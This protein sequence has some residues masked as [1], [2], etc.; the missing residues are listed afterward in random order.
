MRIS[1]SRLF[2]LCGLA[3]QMML[4]QVPARAQD[5]KTE[6]GPA[7]TTPA[8]NKRR[9]TPATSVP[10]R[11]GSEV[12]NPVPATAT[13]PAPPGT[14]AKRVDLPAAGRGAVGAAPGASVSGTMPS[15]V[16]GIT[17]AA[18]LPAGVQAAEG[19]IVGK[20]QKPGKDLQDEVV[21]LSID[22]TRN[23][24]A[25]GGTGA[26]PATVPAGSERAKGDTEKAL[27]LVLTRRAL[28]SLHTYARTSDGRPV[29][30]ALNPNA[31]DVGRSRS[32]LTSTTV[33]TPPLVSPM[34]FTMLKP[35]QF[36]A[37]Q[38]RKSGNLNE[39]VSMAVI[40]TSA[41]PAT[42]T[43]NNTVTGGTGTG[44]VG[45]PARTNATPGSTTPKAPSTGR[46]PRIPNA[47]VGADANPQ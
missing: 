38:Y 12:L 42:G 11:V 23:W 1:R 17:Q 13:D 43:P 15:N 28:S 10:P 26:A 8:T 29:P 4:L 31:P 9:E 18:N 5:G 16:P 3:A 7:V 45:S 33:A 21:R 47:T 39:V 6:T 27:D 19:V 30:D 40:V 46:V 36:V 14:R 22:P 24:S 34:N 32:G 37:V 25:F 41:T 44:T 20:V 2:G 35:G